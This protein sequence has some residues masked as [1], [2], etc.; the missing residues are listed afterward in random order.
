MTKINKVPVSKVNNTLVRLPLT[1]QFNS[2][3][4]VID[5]AAK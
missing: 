1:G 2:Q 3:L 4:S 5:Q